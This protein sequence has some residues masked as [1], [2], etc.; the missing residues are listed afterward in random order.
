MNKK[1]LYE[2]IMKN[3]AIEVKK[4]LNEYNGNDAYEAA[5]ESGWPED[6]KEY[7]D[8][9]A[10]GTASIYYGMEPEDFEDESD[11]QVGDMIKIIDLVGDPAAERYKGRTGRIEYID[12]MGQLHGTWGGLAVIPGEDIFEIL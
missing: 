9:L 3:V 6:S 2:H 7:N 4:A 1:A 10:N 11:P 12:D 8:I 5:E